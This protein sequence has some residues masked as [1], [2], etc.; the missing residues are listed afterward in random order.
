[1]KES[2]MKQ[3][4]HRIWKSDAGWFVGENINALIGP[5]KKKAQA[6]V[7]RDTLNEAANV[8]ISETVTLTVHD[9]ENGIE[10]KVDITN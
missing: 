9:R 4:K 3:I 6:M 10:K 2:Q 8:T 5:F 7:Y 1:M